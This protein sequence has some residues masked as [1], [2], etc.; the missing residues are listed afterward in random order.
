MTER[1]KGRCV[2]VAR[3][4]RLDI[5]GDDTCR[6][7]AGAEGWMLSGHARMAGPEGRSRLDYVVWADAEWRTTG[8]DVTGTQDGRPVGWRIRRDAQGWTLDDQR[9]AGLDGA[10]DVD[11]SFTPATNLLPLRRLAPV[12]GAVVPVTA[13]WFTYPQIALAPLVQS[14]ER[15]SDTTLAYRSP[16]FQA[17]LTADPSGFVTDYPGLWRGAVTDD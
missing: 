15:L 7:I 6:L 3:W 10:T 9:I 2:A 16:D 12:A 13:A 4:Q 11:L 5:E 1:A 14:Y 17:R 8:A